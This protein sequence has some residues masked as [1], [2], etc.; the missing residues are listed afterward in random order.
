MGCG[1]ITLQAIDFDLEILR[2]NGIAPL[3]IEAANVQLNTSNKKKS[4]Q[5]DVLEIESSDEDEIDRHVKELK[6]AVPV[7]FRVVKLS[8]FQGK[9]QRLESRRRAKKLKVELDE[10]KHLPHLNEVIDLT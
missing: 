1:T 2:A 6:V 4:S 5:I 8:V 7:F 9:L 10:Q 3:A